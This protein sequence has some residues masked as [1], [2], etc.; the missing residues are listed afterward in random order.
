[1]QNNLALHEK[2]ELHELLTFKNTC[3][4]KSSTMKNLVG[5]EELKGI[6]SS[7]VMTGKQHI[8]QIQGFLGTGDS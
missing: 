4:T 3:V 5:C 1:M 7:D 6:L 8:Q 2:L